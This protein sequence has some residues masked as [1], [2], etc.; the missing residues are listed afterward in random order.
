MTREI[1]ID[2]ITRLS[3][4]LKV[5]VTIDSNRIT[6]AKCTD[7]V[8]R[9][10]EYMLIGKSPLDALYYTERICGICSTAHSYVST[11]AVES[12]L[13]IEC[14]PNSNIIRNFIHG[15]EFLQNHIRHFYAFVLPDYIKGR[16]INPN[17]NEGFIDYRLPHY[18][19]E[20]LAGHYAQGLSY[21]S[22]AHQILEILGSKA[23]HNHGIYLGGNAINFD[24]SQYV[25]INSILKNISDF[26]KEVM[27]EDMDIIALYYTDYFANGDTGGNY[28]SYG[29]NDDY[30][31]ANTYY[32]KPTVMIKGK[33]EELDAKK[34]QAGSA[35]YDGRAMEVGPLARMQ[36]V[37][38]YTRGNSTM[39]RIKARVLECYR[40]ASTMQK[41]LP[42]MEFKTQAQ[43]SYT[44]P[45][46]AYGRAL[47]DTAR[48]ALGHFISI[49]NKK[50][51]GYEIMTPSS[52]NFSPEDS[53]GEKGIL[54]K[55]LIG[56]NI[57]D[58]QFPVEIGRI[59]RSFDP[60]LS[61]STRVTTSK[62][63]LEFQIL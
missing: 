39:D 4:L 1:I 23:P 2:S 21:S 42:M 47:K 9:D 51:R 54:E 45:E 40:I 60:C 43:E 19:N 31:N 18:V 50:I 27:L 8:F 11:M 53:T 15:C 24:V 59:I 52:W 17:F 38:E 32:I 62:G 48:G 22:M 25:E 36:L 57:E 55:A 6:K 49:E 30:N 44:V 29:I 5:E 28:L 56:S 58:E 13:N 12:A 63:N 46:N 16:F 20:R 41:L 7:N 61:C 14:D 26:I 34:I 3:R 10:I 37:G 33:I 35:R